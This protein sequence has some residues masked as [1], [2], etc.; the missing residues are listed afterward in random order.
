MRAE[1]ALLLLNQSRQARAGCLRHTCRRPIPW[2]SRLGCTKSRT[3]LGAART[4]LIVALLWSTVAVT[5]FAAPAALEVTVSSSPVR[6]GDRVPVRVTARGGGDL[7]W[8]ELQVAVEDSSPWALVDPPQELTG[9]RPPVWQLVLAPMDV[10][11][12][13]L[14]A[15][16]V[17]VRYADGQADEIEA[18]DLP[19]A[20]VVSVLPADQE[21]RP[22]PLRDPVGVSGIP[23]EW[24]LPLAVPL[25]GAAAALA[26]WGR[27]RR[28][29]VVGTGVAALA[30]FDELSALLDRLDRRVGRQPAE[31][32]CDRLAGGLRRYLERASGEPAE[33]MTS[34]ELRLLA[35]QQEWPDPVRRGIQAVMSTADRV[36]FGRL[37]AD[38]SELRRVIEA[39]RETARRLEDHLAVGD[40]EVEEL[41]ATG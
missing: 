25:L 20:N 9:T 28:T 18:V 23:W 10:G 13:A 3:L 8:G 37:P 7:M 16:S 38:D 11:E 34:F 24:V 22:A 1:L 5:S 4:S 2:F 17:G 30:P 40:Q 19:R 39:G 31:S 32:I 6:V 41:E 12:I 33:E 14:P 26:W 27:R 21:A 36:R 35:R 15:L 29:R